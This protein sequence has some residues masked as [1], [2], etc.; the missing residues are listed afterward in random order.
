VEN[1]PDNTFFTIPTKLENIR[2]CAEEIG[3]KNNLSRSTTDGSICL[4]DVCYDG[5]NV[6]Y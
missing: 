2:L 5:T 4:D 6:T 1:I 3:C